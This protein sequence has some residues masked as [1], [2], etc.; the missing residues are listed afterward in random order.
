MACVVV[1]AGCSFSI[2]AGSG[3][4]GGV[5]DD[6]GDAPACAAWQPQHVDPCTLVAPSAG[7]DLVAT[8]TYVYDTGTRMLVDPTGTPVDHASEERAGLVVISAD[9]LLVGPTSRLRAIGPRP[10]LVAAWTTMVIEGHID[11]SST[12]GQPGAGATTAVCT[13]PSPGESDV[14]G[15]A[16]GGGGGFGAAG[17]RG[18]D[19]DSNQ[20]A[21]GDGISIGAEPG[22]A[23]ALPTTVRA[24]CPGGA[25]GEGTIAMRGLG[26]AGGGAFELVA[27]DSITVRGVLHAGGQ[28]GIGVTNDGGG[29]GGG[30]GGYIGLDA[31]VITLEGATVAANGGAGAGGGDDGNLGGLGEDG[32]ASAIVAAG[33]VGGLPGGTRG[34]DGGVAGASAGR[35]VTIT[36][37]GGG[38]GGGGG[39]GMILVWS[40]SFMG[41]N[42]TISPPVITNP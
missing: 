27:K 10:L 37:T 21:G 30:S 41:L 7:L 5:T 24:G 28:G 3:D 16:G 33:G 23:V 31:P 2:P 14:G 4:D 29:G 6:S 1:V 22:A 25:G 42:A 39:V 11:A 34:G 18:G 20:D 36:N 19:G 9:H 32:K 38:G 17:G 13:T 35:G 40:P 12:T 26:G 15:A 8:G